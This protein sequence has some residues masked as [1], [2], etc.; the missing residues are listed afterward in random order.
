MA[1]LADDPV[2]ALAQ[3]I[4][5]RPATADDEA[6][7]LK[8]FG[9]TRE[10]FRFL[11]SAELEALIRMQ[12]TLQ[13]QQYRNRYPNGEDQLIIR[14]G[15]PIGRIFIDESQDELTLVDIALLPEYRG[16][17]IGH[18]LLARLLSRATAGKKP[19]RLHV[20]NSNPARRLYERL[21]F[22]E[23]GRD[24]MYIEM[25]FDGSRKV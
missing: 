16:R 1:R 6:F 22:T 20:F 10:E 3:S 9:S 14:H 5:L 12:F 4:S 19:V 21:G 24:S 8:L 17:G 13:H 15:E 18:I 25:Q 7:L 2:D 23:T 11:N